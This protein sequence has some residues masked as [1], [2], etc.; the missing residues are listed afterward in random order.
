ML[1]CHW[2]KDG[3]QSA[4]PDS[5]GGWKAPG[6][7]CCLDTGMHLFNHEEEKLFH[8]RYFYYNRQDD[9]DVVSSWSAVYA[10]CHLYCPGCSSLHSFHLCSIWE[11]LCSYFPKGYG[12]L[13]QNT[14]SRLNSY[15]HPQQDLHRTWRSSRSSSTRMQHTKRGGTQWLQLLLVIL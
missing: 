9:L 5:G 13:L 6:P 14:P 8:S 2:Q 3:E 12:T 15:W 4:W 7:K 11:S 10:I 1:K